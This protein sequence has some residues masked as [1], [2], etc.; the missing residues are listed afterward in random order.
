[1]MI[2]GWLLQNFDSVYVL[3]QETM[4]EPGGAAGVLVNFFSLISYLFSSFCFWKI[5]QKFGEDNAWFAWV[6]ILGQWKMYQVGGQSP[7]WVIGLFIPLINIV[8][9]VFLIMAMV[10]IVKRL[11]K[12]PWLIL[13][14]IIPLVNFWVLYHFAFQ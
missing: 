5:Y 2:N 3:A 7:W 9:L 11:G 13:L 14:M 4:A 1:M 6:P 10:N 12:N 8:A